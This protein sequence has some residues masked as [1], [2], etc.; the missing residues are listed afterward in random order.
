MTYCRICNF[1]QFHN[2][3]SDKSFNSTSRADNNPESIVVIDNEN[4][5]CNDKANGDDD[6]FIQTTDI[7]EE[8]NS[9]NLTKIIDKNK[10]KSFKRKN[11]VKFNR[12]TIVKRKFYSRNYSKN[13]RQKRYERS[14]KLLILVS[15]TFVICW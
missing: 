7:R 14:K 4:Y 5:N 1:L 11:Q 8:R 13:L 3:K 9:V 15:L 2:Y 12:E 6:H 10:K